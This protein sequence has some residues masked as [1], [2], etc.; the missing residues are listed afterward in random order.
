MAEDKIYSPDTI[1]DNPLPNQYESANYSSSQDTSNETFSQVKIPENKPP[2]KKIAYELIG[3]ALNTKSKKIL[4]EFQFT[5]SG[6][7]Q[8]G[9]YENGV[10][11]DLRLTPNGI[12]ARDDAGVTT[13][14]IDGSTGNAVFRGTIQTGT[15]ISGVVIVG[16]N[17]WVIDGDPDSPSIKLHNDG[18]PEIVIGE[19]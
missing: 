3:S 7:I 13:F 2:T 10:S 18:V 4:A 11:G 1:D 5:E 12:T 15:L 19:P 17:T 9:K 8:I 16:N 14:A 6:A